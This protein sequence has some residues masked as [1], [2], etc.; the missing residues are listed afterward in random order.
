MV[1]RANRAVTCLLACGRRV[2]GSA[3]VPILQG[4]RRVVCRQRWLSREVLQVYAS[5]NGR[6]GSMCNRIDVGC[7][8]AV[9]RQ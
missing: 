9:R 8:T 2:L 7:F 1:A 5:S 6:L 4:M 3:R